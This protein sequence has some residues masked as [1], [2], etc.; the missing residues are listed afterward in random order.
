MLGVENLLFFIN[1]SITGEA[2][3]IHGLQNM[4]MDQKEGRSCDKPN[5]TWDNF[6]TQNNI[7]LNPH[8][9]IKR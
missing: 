2:W 8:L 6:I 1:N 4:L 3:N 9:N 7:Q 5:L